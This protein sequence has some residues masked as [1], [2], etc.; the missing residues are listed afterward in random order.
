MIDGCVGDLDRCTEW[1]FVQRL[2][3]RLDPLCAGPLVRIHLPLPV[4]RAIADVL[5][6]PLPQ[7]S[8]GAVSCDLCARHWLSV[9][10]SLAQ[11]NLDCE[12]SWL[13]TVTCMLAG[14]DARE[15]D[16]LLRGVRYSDD[17]RQ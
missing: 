1:D 9:A 7:T 11:N 3:V 8:R 12:A 17:Y 10:K 13:M 6:V 15:L 5:L 16:N 14:W 2:H 4:R